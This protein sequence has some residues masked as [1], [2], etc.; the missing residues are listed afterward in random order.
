MIEDVFA[1]LFTLTPFLG[2]LIVAIVNAPNIPYWYEVIQ[3]LFFFIFV[4]RP[5]YIKIKYHC[6]L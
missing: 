2:H 5:L 6:I 1:V 4:S 3:I